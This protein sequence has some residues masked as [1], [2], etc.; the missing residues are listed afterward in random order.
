MHIPIFQI[1]VTVK[2]KY[3]YEKILSCRFHTG[4]TNK[5]TEEMS[6]EEQLNFQVDVKNI[7]WKKYLEEIHIPGLIKYVING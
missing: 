7:N 6:K 1:I 5:L 3:T 2:G 4:N